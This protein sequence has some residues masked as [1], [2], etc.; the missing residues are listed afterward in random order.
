MHVPTV[1]LLSATELYI[2]NTGARKFEVNGELFSDGAWHY[3]EIKREGRF[4]ALTVD[5]YLRQKAF[6]IQFVL[7]D[8]ENRGWK[9]KRCTLC[10]TILLQG[11]RLSQLYKKR[12]FQ[13]LVQHN[14]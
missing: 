1:D 12:S 2:L 8:S 11:T 13:I 3:L 6:N 9:C 7:F 4:V 5:K 10:Y 14:I